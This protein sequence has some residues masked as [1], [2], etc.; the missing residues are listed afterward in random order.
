LLLFVWTF[1]FVYVIVGRTFYEPAGGILNAWKVL[2]AA[3]CP[4]N[5]VR[6]HILV[7]NARIDEERVPS[8]AEIVKFGLGNDA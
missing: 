1:L 6:Q 4:V 3:M 5:G 7:L 8:E 2:P